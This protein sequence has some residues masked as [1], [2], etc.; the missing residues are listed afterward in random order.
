MFPYRKSTCVNC[1]QHSSTIKLDLEHWPDIR[2]SS[3]QIR[4]QTKSENANG[5]IETEG[6]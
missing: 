5:D 3:V 6:S 4:L 1:V 2:T